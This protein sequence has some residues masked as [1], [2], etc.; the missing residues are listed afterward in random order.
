MNIIYCY[1]IFIWVK[2]LFLLRNKLC[3]NIEKF[4]LTDLWV[5]IYIYIYIYKSRFIFLYKF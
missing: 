5:F 4:Y 3:M 2:K 1:E